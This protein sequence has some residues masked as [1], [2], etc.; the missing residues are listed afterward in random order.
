MITILKIRAALACALF[1]AVLIPLAAQGAA[2]GTAEDEA[3]L[4][5]DIEMIEMIP[6]GQEG[7]A[8]NSLLVSDAVRVGGSFSGSADMEMGWFDPWNNGADPKKADI[9]KLDPNLS[10]LLFFDARPSAG[11][12]FYGSMK[13]GWPFYTEQIIPTTPTSTTLR[14]PD[15]KVFKLFTDFTW[16]D[17]AFFRFGKQTVTW[18]VGYFFSPADVL[19]LQTIDVLNPTAQREGPVT[20]RMNIPI[21][22]S[23]HNIWAYGVVDTETLVPED[24]AAAVKGEFVIGAWELGLGGYYKRDTPIRGVFTASGS[25]KDISLFGEATLSRGSEKKWANSVTAAPPF[26][27]TTEDKTSPFFKGTAGFMYSNSDWKMNVAGQY[28]FDGEGYANA[29]REARIAEAHT[30]ESAIKAILALSSDDPDAAFSGLLKGL[31]ANSGQHYVALNISRTELFVDDLSLSVFG[32][33]NLSDLSGFVR[34]SLS[35]KIFTGLNASFSALIAF[36]ATD[37][38]YLVLNDGPKVSFSFGLN[39]GSGSF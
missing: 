21:P 9:Y 26:V 13:T 16:N 5:G 34:P 25:I 29:D 39:F 12:R 20:L 6:E 38:E 3:A 24:I 22:N 10:A 11:M 19:N 15:I 37:S 1:A 4:F 28:L 36:G 18:G 35:Y 7:D 2:A 33:G 32:M 31:I 23:Q 30:N 8:V 17:K 27:T 14:L